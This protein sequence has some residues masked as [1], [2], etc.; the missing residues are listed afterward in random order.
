MLFSRARRAIFSI[1][2]I[3]A[4]SG[5]MPTPA[6]AQFT[7]LFGFGDSYADTG[8][9]P[10]GAYRLIG[11]NGTGTVSIPY[12]PF[13]L[14]PSDFWPCPSPTYTSC[15]FT[16]STNFV[17]SLQSIYGLSGLTNYSIG[18][19]RTDNTN[20]MPFLS[21]SY[22]LPYEL[23]QFVASGTRFTDSDLIAL[24]IGGNDLSGIN[25]SG[26]ADVNAVISTSA[27]VSAVNAV[28]GVQQLVAAGARNIAWLGTGS[29][30]W[31][32]E[33]TLGKDGT[34]PYNFSAPQRDLWADTY[35]LQTQ[36]L[37]APLAQAGV[38][39]FL[40]NFGILQQRVAENP[41]MYGFAGIPAGFTG[42][43]AGPGTGSTP[44]TVAVNV[45]GCFYENSVHPTGAAMALIASYMANQIDAP[46]TVTP[47]AGVATSLLG[48]FS[49]SVF[50]R[51][52]AGRRFQPSGVHAAMAAIPGKAL[53]PPAP[54]DRWSVYGAASY[55]GGSRDRQFYATGYDYDAAG[56]YLG[57]E[58]RLDANWRVGGVFGYS[59]PDVKLAVQDARNRIDAFQ[60]AG[61]GSYTDAHWFADGLVA[62][63]RQNFA[64]ERRGVIDIIRASTKADV[65][66]VAARGGYLFDAGRLRVGPIAA[67]NYTNATIR[68]YTETG[69]VLLAMMVDRQTLDTLTG[70]AGVQ[71]RYPLQLGDG[72]YTPFLNL[73]AAHDFLGS[74]HTVTTTLV[75]APLLPILTPVS[76]DGGTY[77]R[78]AGGISALVASNVAATLTGTTSFA[79]RGGND[80]GVTGGVRLSF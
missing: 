76:A 71:L 77:G 67:L 18:G 80:A 65:V 53:A 43:E 8:S 19:A 68:G 56:G 44:G 61:Y 10:G 50:D 37:L 70:D 75:S 62:Y 27:T 22:G 40:L 6:Q 41:A 47:Q 69:D 52:E 13:T 30:K 79:R 4:A 74:G 24:S 11:A 63:G 38:R 34:N 23:Q 60:F 72:S 25:V 58:Y 55:A 2:V 54:V 12:F 46:S 14:T 32:P 66:T 57:L 29:S 45:A 42:C 31:F 49:N 51:L 15:R 64:L 16:G 9:A 59:Q 1:A 17:D 26:A 36:Q 28:A 7:R 39:I 35:Y 21:S 3:A 33:A 48:G 78:V 5:I 73:T 20:T